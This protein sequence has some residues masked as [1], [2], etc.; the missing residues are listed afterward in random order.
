MLSPW[1]W[2]LKVDEKLSSLKF[3]LSQYAPYAPVCKELLYQGFCGNLDLNVLFSEL[4]FYIVP[5]LHPVEFSLI[6]DTGFAAPKCPGVLQSS[7]NL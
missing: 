3:L 6:F 7:Y 2:A 4:I 1:K 5:T